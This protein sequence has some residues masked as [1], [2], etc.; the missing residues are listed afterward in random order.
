MK[1]V[2]KEQQEEEKKQTFQNLVIGT[3]CFLKIKLIFFKCHWICLC[4]NWLTSFI[5]HGQFQMQKIVMTVGFTKKL[6]LVQMKLTLNCNWIWEI[7]T[8]HTV[9]IQSKKYVTQCENGAI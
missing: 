2:K 8:F 3:I 9:F 1:E 5:I 7:H 6:M 4:M